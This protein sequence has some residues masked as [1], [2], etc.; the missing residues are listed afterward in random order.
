MSEVLFI[1]LVAAFTGV[2]HRA[3]YRSESAALF[4]K[5][6]VVRGTVPSVRC[7]YHS[8]PCNTQSESEEITITAHRVLDEV[9]SSRRK[10]QGTGHINVYLCVYI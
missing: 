4:T 2:I 9:R 5:E 6:T 10:M 3:I 1:V 7:L 8:E